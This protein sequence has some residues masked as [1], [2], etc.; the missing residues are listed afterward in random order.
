[1]DIYI[2][3]TRRRAQSGHAGARREV[4][5]DIDI[6]IYVCMYMYMDIDRQIDR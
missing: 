5:I 1:M 6:D 4:Y 3:L 2:E